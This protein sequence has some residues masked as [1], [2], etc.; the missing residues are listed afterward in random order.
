MSRTSLIIVGILC[1]LV[2]AA[3]LLSM[4]SHA[5][6]M[7]SLWNPNSQLPIMVLERSEGRPKGLDLYRVVYLFD[8][9]G[10]LINYLGRTEPEFYLYSRPD[11]TITV[12]GNFNEFIAGLK[13]FPDQAKIDWVRKCTVSFEYGMPDNQ[14][15]ILLETIKDKN[16]KMMAGNY[17]GQYYMIECCEFRDK[18]LQ[19]PNLV[20]QEIQK[21]KEKK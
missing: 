15:K 4:T 1:A 2:T 20:Y 6:L 16:V 12:T 9:Y 18:L 5:R 17:D 7:K 14:R 19:N 10:F 3:L 8:D 11:W 13:R 21:A